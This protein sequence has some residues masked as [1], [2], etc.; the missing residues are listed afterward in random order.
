MG[1]STGSRIRS[2]TSERRISSPAR[3]RTFRGIGGRK[4]LQLLGGKPLVAH[5][6]QAALAAR[7]VTRVLCTTDDPEIADVARAAGVAAGTPA[8]K[9]GGEAR[10]EARRRVFVRA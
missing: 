4:N 2:G 6:V 1:A 9:N 10:V 5:A 7:C 3:E 8:D